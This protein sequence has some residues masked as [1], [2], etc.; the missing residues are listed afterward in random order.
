[1]VEH[2]NPAALAGEKRGS[3]QSAASRAN[4]D[5]FDVSHLRSHLETS[6]VYQ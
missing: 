1:L 6:T 2:E 4:Y 3:T 5:D